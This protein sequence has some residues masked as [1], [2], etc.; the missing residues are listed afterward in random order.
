MHDLWGNVAKNLIGS[1]DIDIACCNV[2]SWRYL[3]KGT[4]PTG[5]LRLIADA[6][7]I[8]GIP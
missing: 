5:S 7:Q 6:I 1:P 8:I 2:G 3:R 4:K